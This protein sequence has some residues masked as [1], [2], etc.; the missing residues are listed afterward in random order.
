M[1]TVAD[2]R[3][4]GVL[5]PSPFRVGERRQD[6]AD[7]WT[8][9]LEPVGDGFAVAPGQFVM[10]YAFG[11]GE[12]P[13]S[14]S[15]PPDRPGEPVVLTVRDVGAVTHAICSSEPG[16]TLGLRGP[17]G[18]SWPVE[19]GSGGDVLVV[20]GG[21]GLA[22]LRPV[23]LHALAH[24]SEYGAASVLYGARTPQDLLYTDELRRWR[25]ELAV[26]VTVDAADT[27]WTG[28]V[29]VVPKLVERAD[30]RPEAVRAFVCGPEVMIHFTVE[31]LRGRGVPD[32]RIFLSL[33]RD[34]RCGVG[35]CGHCQ[36]GPTLICRDG[37]VYSQAQVT[38][39]LEVRE[40]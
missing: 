39:L 20:A 37:P 15:G 1:A 27:S 9:T 40:L 11:V 18:N 6:T 19:A 14:V 2:D 12:V 23:V 16:T 31:A 4:V 22:P 7:T 3:A 13:I 28:R 10:V 32:E 24:R 38:R 5:V 25:E 8:L 36:L 29:G 34:M 33:E 35:L 21:I 17:F 26:E 30:F